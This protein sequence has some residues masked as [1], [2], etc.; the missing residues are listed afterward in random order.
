MMS[1]VLIRGLTRNSVI[2]RFI[3]D[4]QKSNRFLSFTQNK[5]IDEIKIDFEN[6]NKDEKNNR[7]DG[8]I[9]EEILRNAMKYVPIYGFSV[10][11]ILEGKFTFNLIIK[12]IFFKNI[13]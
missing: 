12:F 10:Q 1:R 7:D 6:E 9:K 2:K 3:L 5:Q 11:S 13:F 8:E 4:N